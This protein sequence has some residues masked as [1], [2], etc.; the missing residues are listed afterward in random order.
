MPKAHT[1]TKI[2]CPRCQSHKDT[3][4]VP[5]KP[6]YDQRLKHFVCDH[7]EIGWYELPGARSKHLIGGIE[8]AK[9]G[10]VAEGKP[11]KKAGQR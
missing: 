8:A 5:T 6:G 3:R 10:Y 4:K 1:E 9:R 7:C 11:A 2:T